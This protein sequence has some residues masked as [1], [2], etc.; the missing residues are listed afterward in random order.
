MVLPSNL[1]HASCQLVAGLSSEWSVDEY[2]V[3]L[4]TG[5]GKERMTS[6]FKARQAL[7]V[8]LPCNE[9]GMRLCSLTWVS[10]LHR[11]MKKR[12]LSRAIKTEAKRK[13]FVAELHKLKTNLFMDM[14][15]AGRMPLR[16]GVA[17]LVG[18]E[19]LGQKVAVDVVG[20]CRK[21]RIEVS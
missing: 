12:S 8:E 20:S 13:D 6:Y 11:K 10:N 14:V 3:L 4:E 9:R 19:Y 15:M 17:R 21:P 2:G 5:G 7:T 1:E 16:P 18:V